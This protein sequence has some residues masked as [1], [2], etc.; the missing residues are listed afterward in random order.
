MCMRLALHKSNAPKNLFYD[1]IVYRTLKSFYTRSSSAKHTHTHTCAHAHTTAKR[2]HEP[3]Y[4]FVLAWFGRFGTH[5][6]APY[7]VETCARF[8]P[9]TSY[10]FVQASKQRS[11]RT[12]AK[13]ERNLSS[14]EVWTKIA[15]GFDK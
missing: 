13:M 3:I 11:A 14:P 15:P 9:P 5:D 4:L 8:I 12:G 10:D 6:T 1:Y 7:Y 2:T